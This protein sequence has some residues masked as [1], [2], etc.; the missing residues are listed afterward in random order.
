[1]SVPVT[2]A[3]LAH[4]MASMGNGGC[5]IRPRLSDTDHRSRWA[6]VA[7]HVEHKQHAV[8]RRLN[9]HQAYAFASAFS[10]RVGQTGQPVFM[11]KLSPEFLRIWSEPAAWPY[12][13]QFEPCSIIAVS[14]CDQ[15]KVIGSLVVWRDTPATPFV[16]DDLVFAEQVAQ[17]LRLVVR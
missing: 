14:V 16:D 7:A 13:E 1:M 10:A 8:L 2:L 12:L 17:R 9:D 6:P 15:K 11:P 3:A 5:I 4:A